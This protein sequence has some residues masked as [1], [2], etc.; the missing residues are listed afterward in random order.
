MTAKVSFVKNKVKIEKSFDSN[1]IFLLF[2]GFED[3]S[4][5]KK[6]FGK[7][8]KKRFCKLKHFC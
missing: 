6:F 4:K 2:L 7:T 1:F 8:R 5:R 3:F